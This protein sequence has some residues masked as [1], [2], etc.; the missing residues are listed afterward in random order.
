MPSNEQPYLSFKRDGSIRNY[1]TMAN[2]PISRSLAELRYTVLMVSLL[3]SVAAM[4]QIYVALDGRLFNATVALLLIAG[5]V[6]V[7]RKVRWGRW[8]AVAFLWG[9]ILIGFGTINP[10]HAGDLIAIG[11]EP[12]SLLT[13][14][15]KF[16]GICAIAL[17]CLH[18]LG[19]YK[20]LFR[21]AWI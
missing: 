2:E 12:P 20:L 7:T 3:L 11:I 4:H 13:L 16:A 1:F 19:K 6:G 18:Y 10:F 14:G 17:V 21:P 9:W 8:I 5:V 15:L